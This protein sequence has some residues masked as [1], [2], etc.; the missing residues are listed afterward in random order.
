VTIVV[1]IVPKR[2]LGAVVVPTVFEI[3]EDDKEGTRFA[4]LVTDAQRFFPVLS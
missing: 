1:E 4:E 3:D 2:G